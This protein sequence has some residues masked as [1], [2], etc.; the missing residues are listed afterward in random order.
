MGG[1]CIPR[2]VLTELQICQAAPGINGSGH[3]LASQCEAN[4]FVHLSSVSQLRSHPLCLSSLS[5]LDIVNVSICI[6]WSTLPP[7]EFCNSFYCLIS[8]QCFQ[9]LSSYLRQLQIYH[10]LNPPLCQ[11]V[12]EGTLWFSSYLP[13]SKA[14]VTLLPNTASGQTVLDPREQS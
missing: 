4:E 13:V 9:S 10:C 6:V 7:D 5:S 1:S 3:W 2:L 8:F 11:S 12:G 14:F